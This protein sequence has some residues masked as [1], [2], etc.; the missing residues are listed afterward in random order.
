MYIMK[1][2][3]EPIVDVTQISNAS[4]FTSPALDVG[5]YIWLDK[6]V[7]TFRLTRRH[8]VKA[9]SSYAK[10]L[11]TNKRI[12]CSYTLLHSGALL[13]NLSGLIPSASKLAFILIIDF[14][15]AT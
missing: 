5:L 7:T 9:S 1:L 4:S 13:G 10:Q 2:P 11:T 12:H 3:I 14:S 8:Y 15:I 6:Y